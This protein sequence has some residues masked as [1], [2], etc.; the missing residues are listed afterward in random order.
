MKYKVIILLAL[1][2]ASLFWIS[3]SKE[4]INPKIESNDTNGYDSGRRHADSGKL[5]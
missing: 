5:N 2:L 4:Q 1:T 3:C